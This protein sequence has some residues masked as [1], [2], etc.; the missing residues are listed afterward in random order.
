MNTVAVT[1][2]LVSYI[3]MQI[4]LHLLI[5]QRTE[6][7]LTNSQARIYTMN[8]GSMIGSVQLNEDISTPALVWKFVYRFKYIWKYLEFSEKKNE[9]NIEI[10]S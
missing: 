6:A 5:L 3:H 9:N 4:S 7:Q 8:S 10:F 1:Y 2:R